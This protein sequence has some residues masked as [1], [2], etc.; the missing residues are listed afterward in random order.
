MTDYE[1]ACGIKKVIV[2]TAAQIIEYSWGADFSLTELKQ[3]ESNIKKNPDFKY[4]DT[5]NILLDELKSLGFSLWDEESKLLLIPLWI[6]NYLK[7]DTEIYCIDGKKSN[8]INSVDK[9]VRFGCI[10]WGIKCKI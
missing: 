8:D 6:C 10:A 5:S 9:D 2:N 4:I 1:I 7:K 3:L